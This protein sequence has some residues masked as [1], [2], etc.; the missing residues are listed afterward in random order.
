MDQQQTSQQNQQYMEQPP[1]VIS[2]KDHL[3]IKDM[4][5]WNLNTIKK[6]N[7]F[8]QQCQDPEIK[9]AINQACQ[10]HQNHYS[11]LLSHINNHIQNAT[12]PSTGGMQ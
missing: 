11:R 8:A 7:F 10:M 12:N 2:T 1:N 9:Q 6:F 3:Y 4:M 5:S